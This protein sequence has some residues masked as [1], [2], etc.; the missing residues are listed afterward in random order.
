MRKKL[1]PTRGQRELWAD[2]FNSR[3][4]THPT[5]CSEALRSAAGMMVTQAATRA[6]RQ[7]DLM[8]QA[9]RLEED[10]RDPDEKSTTR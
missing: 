7:R 2:L 8:T 3:G 6:E 9:S 1:S 4:Q 10:S 5:K